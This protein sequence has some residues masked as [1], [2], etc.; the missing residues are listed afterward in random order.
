MLQSTPEQVLVVPAREA[1]RLLP[2]PG[3][4]FYREGAQ[5]LLDLVEEE[6]A[7][8][9]RPRAEEDVELKQIIPYAYLVAGSEVFLFRR[10]RGG[11]EARLHDKVS[12]GVGGHVNPSDC[13]GGDRRAAIARAFERE[14]HE[15]LEIS[16]LYQARVEGVLNDDSNPVGQVHIGIVYRVELEE[17]RAKV[18]EADCLRGGFVPIPDVPRYRAA[19]ESWS[20]ILQ[21]MIWPAS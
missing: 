16:C 7:F 19:M 12:L 14:L 17:P 15:E 11:G 8:A 3:P 6:G 2:G 13:P 10:T 5:R 4:G 9:D 20:G 18:R 1:V 21:E